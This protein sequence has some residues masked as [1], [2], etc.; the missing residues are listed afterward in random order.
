MTTRPATEAGTPRPAGNAAA[1]LGPLLGKLGLR[2]TD[3]RERVSDALTG[4]LTRRH[5]TGRLVSLRYHV[6]TVH[7]DPQTVHLLGYDRDHLLAEINTT[8]ADAGAPLLRSLQLTTRL[9][10]AH[11]A[12]PGAAPAAT[13]PTR[14]P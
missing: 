4:A 5:L 10:H 8:L 13:D 6:A 11:H 2:S 3:E 14:H 1:H 7:A 9:N 12:T